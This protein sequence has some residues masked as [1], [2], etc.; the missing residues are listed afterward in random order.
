MTPDNTQTRSN[1]LSLPPFSSDGDCHR[2][3]PGT[4]RSPSLRW[5]AWC[6]TPAE[7]EN[8]LWARL[9]ATCASEND[10]LITPHGSP[11][12][13]AIIMVGQ[14]SCLGDPTDEDSPGG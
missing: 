6:Q 11:P 4:H 13:M 5:V 14:S 8:T 1:V 2:Q 10:L 7:E 9:M 3:A 12:A